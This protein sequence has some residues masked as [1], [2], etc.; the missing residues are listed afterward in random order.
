MKLTSE[1]AKLV[2]ASH[3]HDQFA[4]AH[5]H[6]QFAPDGKTQFFQ[7]AT[8]QTQCRNTLIA[9]G[10]LAITDCQL[11]RRARATYGAPLFY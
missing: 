5:S 3:V 8:A 11:L 4:V 9:G 6:I 2:K 10:V 1:T 7:P